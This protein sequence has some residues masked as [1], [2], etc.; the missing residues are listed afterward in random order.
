MKSNMNGT[1]S[2]PSPSIE[3]IAN[4]GLE[5]GYVAGASGP[6]DDFSVKR[7]VDGTVVTVNHY[8]EEGLRFIGQT[9]GF[10]PDNARMGV[11]MQFPVE[12]AAW[13]A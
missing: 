7:V 9:L 3:D 5:T 2:W 4:C 10:V 8:S 12:E 13:H 11:S 1:E 6:C